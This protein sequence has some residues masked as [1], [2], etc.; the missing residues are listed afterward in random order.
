MTEMNEYLHKNRWGSQGFKDIEL[1][2][3]RLSPTGMKQAKFLNFKIFDN[4]EPESS[5]LNIDLLVSSPLTRAI[6][7]SEIAFNRTK[8]FNSKHDFK[9]SKVINPLASERVYLSSD[10]G[11]FKEE[12]ENEFPQWDYSLLPSNRVWWFEDKN[13]DPN[14]SVPD[15]RPPGWYAVAGEPKEHFRE[16]MIS[17]RKWLIERPEHSIAL[18][19]HWAVAKALTGQDFDNCQVKFILATEL[20]EDPCIDV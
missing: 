13:Y 12:L 17:L 19:C 1:W 14:A 11:K 9:Y 8:F 6:Q 18:T 20:L 5:L 10:I 7:T 4:F 2:D 16:R 3:T 15:W